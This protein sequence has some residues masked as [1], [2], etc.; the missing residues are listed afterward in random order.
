MVAECAAILH[1]PIPALMEMEWSEV[2]LWHDE[3]RRIAAAI[4]GRA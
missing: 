1:T 2:I 4:G 3:A